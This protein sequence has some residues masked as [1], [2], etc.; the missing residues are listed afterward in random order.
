MYS[1]SSI[2]GLANGNRSKS[3]KPDPVDEEPAHD[4]VGSFGNG[5]NTGD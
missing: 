1:K 3:L 2:K 5:W 4:E